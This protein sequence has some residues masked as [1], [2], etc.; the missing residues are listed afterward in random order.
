MLAP[1]EPLTIG[2][3]AN[4]TITVL[5]GAAAAVFAAWGFLT[6]GVRANNA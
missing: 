4:D 3:R 2:V 6:I 1:R 5:E